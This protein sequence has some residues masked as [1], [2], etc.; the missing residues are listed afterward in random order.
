MEEWQ[1]EEFDRLARKA[2]PG[3]NAKVAGDLS[4]QHVGQVVRK[5]PQQVNEGKKQQELVAIFVFF[6]T[7]SSEFDDEWGLQGCM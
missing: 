6:R 7:A 2:L 1:E 5:A 4:Q 3:A